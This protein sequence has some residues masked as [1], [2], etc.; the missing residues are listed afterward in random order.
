[1]MIHAYVETNK[2]V[3]LYSGKSSKFNI[4]QSTI[5]ESLG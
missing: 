2:G 3:V 5:M 4:H 1:M